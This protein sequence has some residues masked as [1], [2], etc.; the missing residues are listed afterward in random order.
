MHSL[1]EYHTVNT[2]QDD[3]VYKKLLLEKFVLYWY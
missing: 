3:L 1:H 2:T